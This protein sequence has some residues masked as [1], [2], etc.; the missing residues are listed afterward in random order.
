TFVVFYTGVLRLHQTAHQPGQYYKP[1]EFY[2][3]TLRSQAALGYGDGEKREF[4]IKNP[5]NQPAGSVKVNLSVNAFCRAML[6]MI[7][8][9]RQDLR[10]ANPQ[11][12]QNYD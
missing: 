3:S 1:E 2:W 7:P 9:S 11:S 8:F 10:N 12:C 4:T 5:W 6:E